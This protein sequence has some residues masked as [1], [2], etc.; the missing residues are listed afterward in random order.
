MKRIGLILT[1]AALVMGAGACDFNISDPNNQQQI[2]PNPSKPVVEA[3]VAGIIIAAS[4]N[5]DGWNL[6]TGSLGLEAYQLGCSVTRFLTELA[7]R[8]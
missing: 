4:S 3:A 6:D 1:V 5:A 8:S 7:Q 2:G